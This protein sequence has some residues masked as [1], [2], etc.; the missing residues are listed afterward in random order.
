V[1]LPIL[2]ATFVTAGLLAL[3]STASAFILGQFSGS[4]AAI[5][6]WDNAI[7]GDLAADVTADAGSPF[8]LGTFFT[9]SFGY[10]LGASDESPSVNEGLY[11]NSL[12]DFSFTG[13]GLVAT[14]G[15]GELGIWNDRAVAGSKF[16]DRFKIYSAVFN[17]PLYQING[18]AWRLLAASLVLAETAVTTPLP[19]GSDA[20][21][22]TAPD[23]SD[24]RYSRMTLT[25][26]IDGVARSG[27]RVIIGSG[28]SPLL[29]SAGAVSNV[30]TPGSMALLLLG[31]AG[32]SR[33]LRPNR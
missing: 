32:M 21:P 29:V 19:L 1:K 10:S 18:N 14:T 31:L 3:S 33:K 15:Q 4:V 5:E 8:T 7:T 27:H 23:S 30:P 20:L 26:A 17:S 13:G 22:A 6:Q 25:F 16:R 24:W 2:A 11:S 12:E 9:G 28:L